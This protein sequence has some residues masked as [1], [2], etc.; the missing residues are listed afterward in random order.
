M[1]TTTL[2]RNIARALPSIAL[3]L[4]LAALPGCGGEESE[5]TG[6]APEQLEAIEVSGEDEYET[7][8]H[9]GALTVSGSER[10]F[11]LEVAT[12]SGSPKLTIHSPGMSDL[13]KLDGLT[14]T[15]TL[16]PMGLH[17][18]RSV[19]IADAD[20]PLYVANVGHGIDADALFGE[21]FADWGET[22]ATSSDELYDWEYT[23]AVFKGDDG[24]VTIEPGNTGTLKLAGATWRVAVI[25]AYKVTPHPDA[26]LPCGGISDLLSYEMIR[27]D[28][29]AEPA[30]LT[31]PANAR[32]AHL[33]CM[34]DD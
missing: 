29:E 2:L 6:T 20:G 32:L 8:E 27:V 31:R 18:E 5:Q 9:Q 7:V 28:A 1:T 22:V 34:A 26:A 15:V 25:A 16:E 17:E 19:M 30:K 14:A 11:S 24:D 12:A 23:P 33:G 21:G 4:G 13:S 3:T 10:D